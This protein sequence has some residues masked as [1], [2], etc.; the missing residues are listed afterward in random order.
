MLGP[1]R[2]REVGMPATRP[3]AEES[4]DERNL[5]NVARGESVAL[6]QIAGLNAAAKPAHALLRAAVSES[7][8]NHVALSAFLNCVVADLGGGVQALFDIARLKDLALAI[9]EAGPDAGKTVCLQLKPHG[10]G[11]G[12]ALGGAPLTGLDLVHD[13]EQVLHVMADFVRNH[14]GLGKI[15][16][17]FETVVEFTKESE[18]DINF[19]VVAAIEGAGGGLREAAR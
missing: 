6:L 4:R 18:V 15:A 14:I 9:G 12:F 16:G 1:N 8:G 10:K 2:L 19:L 17:S 5:R 7:F 11:I 13:A 3:L